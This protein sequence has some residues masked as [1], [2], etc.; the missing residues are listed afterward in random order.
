MIKRGFEEND[1]DCIGRR[2]VQKKN[3]EKMGG[4]SAGGWPR[5]A[6]SAEESAAEQTRLLLEAAET[7]LTVGRAHVVDEG[8]RMEAADGSRV[9]D[10]VRTGAARRRVEVARSGEGA[11]Q[12]GTG[13]TRLERSGLA[14]W[15]MN[16]RTE[17]KRNYFPY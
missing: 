7:G 6:R 15:L 16:C 13:V 5:L 8:L 4:G 1:I 11:V 14:L 10:A 3:E 12:V 9:A 2:T 17:N